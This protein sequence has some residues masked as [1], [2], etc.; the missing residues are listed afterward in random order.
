MAKAKQLT[1]TVQNRPG[2]VAEIARALANAKVNIL[3]VLGMA[4]GDTG[5]VQVVV[6]DNRRAKE[7][8]SKAG[9]EVN[10]SAVQQVELSNVPGALAKS[11][12]KLAGKNVNL[13]SI[14]ATASKGGRKATIVIAE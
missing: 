13:S 11:L 1:I 3:A 10:E 4:H 2:T 12:E 9:F 8:L 7:A 14:Y 6:N 5:T